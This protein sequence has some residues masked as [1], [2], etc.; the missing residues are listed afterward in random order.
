MQHCERLQIRS[1][2]CI[3]DDC[4]AKEIRYWAHASVSQSIFVQVLLCPISMGLGHIGTRTW[5]LNL[6]LYA[7]VP[8][9]IIVSHFHGARTYWDQDAEDW[10][11]PVCSSPTV[12]QSHCVLFPWGWGTLGPRCRT[13]LS[14]CAPVPLCT[15]P[16]SMALGHIGTRMQRTGLS[17][18]APVPLCPIFMG[19]G[20]IGTRTQ[21]TDLSHRPSVHQSHCPIS[22]G[23]GHSGTKTQRTDLSLCAPV[24]LCPNPIVPGSYCVQFLLCPSS[25]NLSHCGHI[26]FHCVPFPSCT[27][28]TVSFHA[29]LC[30]VK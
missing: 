23:L 25:V 12:H 11:L 26:V 18:C 27:S 28:P 4:Q 16:I 13:D 5:G 14:L 8:M 29:F 20:H 24:P 7:S 9:C 30:L 15:S 6:S 10:S 22:M 17:M 2:S 1:I 19:L 21:R 3:F